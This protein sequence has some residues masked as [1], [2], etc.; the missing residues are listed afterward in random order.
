MIPHSHFAPRI[1]LLSPRRLYLN[2]LM[3]KDRLIS[4]LALALLIFGNV[5]AFGMDC[6]KPSAEPSCCCSSHQ[7]DSADGDSNSAKWAPQ[8]CQCHATPS[9]SDGALVVIL[10]LSPETECTP[11]F[12]P[13]LTCQVPEWALW[14]P[15]QDLPCV[16]SPRAPP[17]PLYLRFGVCLS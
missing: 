13:G 4:V 8:P 1:F 14:A 7:L 15:Y 10:G 6:Q 16:N 5:P 17:C 12:Y 2:I 11:E 9:Q 3:M